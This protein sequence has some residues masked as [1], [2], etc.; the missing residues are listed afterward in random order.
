MAQEAQAL[1]PETTLDGDALYALME[2][3][4]KC[5]ERYVDAIN[6]LNVFPV[7]DGD[8]GTNMFLTL[9]SAIESRSGGTVRDVSKAIGRAALLGARGNSGVILSQFLRG[10]ASGLEGRE[11]CDGLAVQEALSAAAS[12]A[13]Q[14]VDRPVEGTMLTV[15]DAAARATTSDKPTVAD[16]WQAATDAAA[17]A[18]AHTPE[19]LP[20]LAEAG[21]VDAGGQGIVTFFAGALAFLRGEHQAD[22]DITRPA[23]P[24]SELPTLVSRD[25]LSRTAHETYGY[26]TQFLI[27]GQNLDI[28]RLRRDVAER[29][30]SVVV[31]GDESVVRVHAHAEDPGPLLTLGAAAGYLDLVKIENMDAMHQDFLAHQDQPVEAPVTAIVAVASGSGIE[32]AFRELGATA[33]IGGGQ[34]MNPSTRELLQAAHG[35]GAAHVLLLPNNPNILAAAQ[36]AAEL[37]EMQCAVVPS[38]SIPQGIAAL[39]VF[40][41]SLDAAANAKAMTAALATV[42]SGEITT[43][44]RD[45]SVGGLQ[46]RKG[47]SIALLEDSV[48]ATAETSEQALL[49]LLSHINPPQGALFTLYWGAEI[50]ADEAEAAQNALHIQRPDI[51]FDLVEGGQ[52]H[53]QYL[54]SVE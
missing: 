34:T 52:P 26:C 41:P 21:V 2:A 50:G 33:A 16:A 10:F 27:R 45:A 15:V 37:G 43:A 51:D 54:V 35:T 48:V 8:T 18:L 39:L 46:I 30:T 6:A 12:A 17:V 20:V 5:L 47:Q 31:V 14:A 32:R 44:V 49:A 25:F 19:Q 29:G 40:N 3:G 22:L 11:W 42:Q 28:E 13:Y 53:Y 4:T 38:R 7:P 1:S 23:V 9:S 36:Q 24:L